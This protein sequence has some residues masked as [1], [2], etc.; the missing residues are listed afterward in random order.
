[1]GA[2]RYSVEAAGPTVARAARTSTLPDQ[3][4]GYF[5]QGEFDFLSGAAIP[6]LD[7]A[8]GCAAA[9]HDNQGY[10][11]ELGVAKFDAG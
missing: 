8:V 11:D 6:E 3:T 7:H 5:V 2:F 4:T 10:S 9:H 1:V